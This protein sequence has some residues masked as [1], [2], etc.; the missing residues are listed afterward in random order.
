MPLNPQTTAVN[1]EDQHQL[2][3]GRQVSSAD[4]PPAASVPTVAKDGPATDKSR[5]DAPQQ[6]NVL[7]DPSVRP[8]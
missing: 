8:F 6:R 4:L 1:D 7:R 2:R 3:P 5:P